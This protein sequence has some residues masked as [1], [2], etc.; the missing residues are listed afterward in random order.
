MDFSPVLF[1]TLTWSHTIWQ[2]V[3]LVS[4]KQMTIQNNT[5]KYGKNVNNHTCYYILIP[6]YHSRQTLNCAKKIVNE[7]EHSLW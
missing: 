6:C 3:I 2:L 7:L 4:L 1:C 5:K